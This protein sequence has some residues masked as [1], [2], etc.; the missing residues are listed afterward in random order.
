MKTDIRSSWV[1]WR[2]TQSRILTLG[3]GVEDSLRTLDGQN[4]IVVIPG[5][6]Q[7]SSQFSRPCT[8]HVHSQVTRA[9]GQCTRTSWKFSRNVLMTKVSL[10]GVYPTW[11][12]TLRHPP[13]C[14]QVRL[15]QTPSWVIVW[16]G[17]NQNDQLSFSSHLRLRRP[18]RAQNCIV[19]KIGS[20]NHPA[21]FDRTFHWMQDL[22]GGF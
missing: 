9:L 5:A 19:E 1:D 13:H 7:D 2:T 14:P 11:V 17:W 15:S 20:P 16:V 3:H 10:Y 21:H 18:N 4:L 8:V 6:L 22:H 12:T